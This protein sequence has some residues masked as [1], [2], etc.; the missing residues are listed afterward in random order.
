MLSS[1]KPVVQCCSCA[2]ACQGYRMP[3]LCSG[4][5][6]KSRKDGGRMQ[7]CRGHH[8]PTD[9]KC[10]FLVSDSGLM[11][12]RQH[13]VPVAGLIVEAKVLDGRTRLKGML[14]AG[15]RDP[16]VSDRVESHVY[17]QRSP[18]GSQR[19]WEYRVR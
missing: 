16:A 12:P 2:D 3:P 11:I 14:P 19:S 6:L 1:L 17:I 13:L 15:W 9:M 7:I 5:A 10:R 4:C 8:V 18:D